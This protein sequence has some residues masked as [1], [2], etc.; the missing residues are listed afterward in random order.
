MSQGRIIS[1]KSTNPFENAQGYLARVEICER[2]GVEGIVVM[3]KCY[4]TVRPTQNLAISNSRNLTTAIYQDGSVAK[5]CCMAIG[6]S[7]P[8]ALYR[9][10]MPRGSVFRRTFRRGED[11]QIVLTIPDAD[12]GKELDAISFSPGEGA[13]AVLFPLRSNLRDRVFS[14]AFVN[15]R[16]NDPRIQKLI[17]DMLAFRDHLKSREGQNRGLTYP[18]Q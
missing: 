2:F 3:V 16:R 14:T 5:I 13:Q 6:N 11:V 17:R 8:D 7:E 18:P 4:L 10:E 12:E 15:A 1:G 9:I